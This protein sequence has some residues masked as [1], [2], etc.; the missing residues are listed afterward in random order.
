[1]AASH[2]QPK[3]VKVVAASHDQP[4][5]PPLT[6]NHGGRLSRSTTVAASY[7][8]LQ[9]PPLTIK[10]ESRFVILRAPK[11]TGLWNRGPLKDVNDSELILN[12][13]K[14]LCGWSSG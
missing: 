13:L 4:R 2:N 11:S 10:L 7:N 5:W 12:V 14:V 9:W 1:M 6:I 3:Q 8:Q